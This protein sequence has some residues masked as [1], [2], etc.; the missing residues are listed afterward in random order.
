ME[1]ENPI[2]EL[3]TDEAEKIDITETSEDLTKLDSFEEGAEENVAAVPEYEPKNKYEKLLYRVYKD[4]NLSEMLKI[5]SYAIVVLTIY[6]FLSCLITTAAENLIGAIELILITGVPFVLVSVLRYAVNAPRPYELIEFYEKKPKD[7][8]GR[9]F[10]SRH[11]FS[12]FVIGVA[13]IP[14]NILLGIT[15]LFLGIALAAIRVLMGIHFI[16]DVL[17]GAAIGVLSGVI[18][19][20]ILHFV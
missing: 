14:T 7:K 10:P 17:A 20:L 9:S 13:L 15:L 3:Q 18:G 16:R 2:N 5:S 6:A 1:N 19:L 11:V 4:E 8:T 12:V